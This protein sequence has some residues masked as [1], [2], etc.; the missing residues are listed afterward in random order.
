M[1][2][3]VLTPTIHKLR[4]PFLKNVTLFFLYRLNNLVWKF[5]IQIDAKK[6]LRYYE[7]SNLFAV[8]LYKSK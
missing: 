5:K 7:I 2:N 1:K 6:V 4:Q 8:F 3:I